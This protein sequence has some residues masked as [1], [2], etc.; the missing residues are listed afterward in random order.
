MFHCITALHYRNTILLQRTL[1]YCTLNYR[2]ATLPQR[3]IVATPYHCNT[4]SLQ[5]R[6]IYCNDFILIHI[7]K[8]NKT[9]SW[10]EEGKGRYSKMQQRKALHTSSVRGQDQEGRGSDTIH[11]NIMMNL[12]RTYKNLAAACQNHK[13]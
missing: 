13:K 12:H 11:W 4:V 3:H 2:N 5:R 6:L 7:Y 8:H 10:E 9:K 1:H